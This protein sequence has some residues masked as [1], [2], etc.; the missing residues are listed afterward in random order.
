MEFTSDL[1]DKAF[2]TLG[3]KEPID[4]T[5][6][7]KDTGID[8]KSVD[9][10]KDISNTERKPLDV[11][12][13]TTLLDTKADKGEIPEFMKPY[14]DILTKKFEFNDEEDHTDYSSLAVEHFGSGFAH[15]KTKDAVY[16]HAMFVENYNGSLEQDE[17]YWELKS[18][19]DTPNN[20][21]QLLRDAIASKMKSNFLFTEDAYQAQLDRYFNEGEL[22][23]DGKAFASQL[24]QMY[25]Q[26]KSRIETTARNEA[27]QKLQQYKEYKN[28]F[29]E[30]IKNYKPFGVELS[31]DLRRH[32]EEFV[33]SGK[34][35]NEGPKNTTDKA[36]REILTALMYSEKAAV[37]FIHSI[38]KDGAKLGANHIQKKFL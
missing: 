12:K 20:E 6:G 25:N 27:N 2:D 21:S 14:E 26:E 33:M 23:S 11:S 37:E 7:V 18:V 17:N 38:H 1:F 19:I 9:T 35:K 5:W 3:F 13:E 16:D 36:R 22:N 32:V 30:E 4:N 31:E 10:L 24:K 8:K 29:R 34:L 15:L 28:A